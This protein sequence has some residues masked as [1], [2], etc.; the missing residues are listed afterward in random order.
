MWFS[1]LVADN[2]WADMH[3]TFHR[4]NDNHAINDDVTNDNI[5][6]DESAPFTAIGDVAAQHDAQML[7]TTPI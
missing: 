5:E 1:F 3:Q 4:E 7:E 6:E 2:H